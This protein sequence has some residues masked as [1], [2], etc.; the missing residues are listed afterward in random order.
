LKPVCQDAIP[1]C[2]R[3]IQNRMGDQSESAALIVSS[4]FPAA[5]QKARLHV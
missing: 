3:S 4:P 2:I 5:L 1:S